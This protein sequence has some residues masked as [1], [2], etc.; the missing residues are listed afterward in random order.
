[1]TG[2]GRNTPEFIRSTNRNPNDSQRALLFPPPPC[3]QL[4][5][6]K[7]LHCFVHSLHDTQCRI[8]NTPTVV[9][10]LYRAPFTFDHLPRT[11]YRA[12]RKL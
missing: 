4:Q 11:I 3:T 12:L 6:S 1:M 5:I 9:V 2:T 7:L 8:H 10:C